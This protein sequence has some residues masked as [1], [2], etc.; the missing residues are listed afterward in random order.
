MAPV[1]DIFFACAPKDFNK[2]PYVVQS[3]V[4][5]IEGYDRI[6]ICVPQQ[7]PDKILSKIN[8][9][10][11]LV[12]DDDVLPGVNR[13]RWKF[14]PNWCFQ[15]HLKLFQEVTQDWYLTLDCDTIVNRR[16]KFFNDD[17]PIYWKGTD[18]FFGPYFIFQVLMIGI[19]KINE[20]SFIADMNFIY[21]PIINDMLKRNNYTRES[22][23]EKS[24]KI[25]TKWCC[26]GEPELYG[27]YCQKYYPSMYNEKYLKHHT[28]GGRP[29]RNLTEFKW[30][31]NEIKQMI[32]RASHLEVDTFSL[33]SWLNEGDQ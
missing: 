10:Y 13:K 17:T 19:P 33:H 23:I 29:Q 4:D 3:A 22:F 1:F 24:Q 31:D 21:R 27:S 32:E 14:R 25:T 30:N 8:V 2:L 5:N 12:Y 28:Y 20:R 11:K 18:Q 16:M 26:I 6:Y 15:Q 7:I 9:D